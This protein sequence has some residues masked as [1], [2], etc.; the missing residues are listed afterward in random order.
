MLAYNNTAELLFAQASNV[1]SS[2]TGAKSS[3][4]AASDD[5]KSVLN[6]TLSSNSK[7]TL[8]NSSID[9]S[10]NVVQTDDNKVKYNSFKEVQRK[11]AV[12]DSKNTSVKQTSAEKSGDVNTET[13]KLSGSS[14]QYDDSINMLAMMLGLQPDELLKLAQQ[15][16]FSAEDLKD[17]KKL[18]LFLNKLADMMEL[19]DSQK[20]MLNNIAKEVTKQLDTPAET[21]TANTIPAE[22]TAVS[23]EDTDNSG[24]NTGSVDISKLSE[25]IKDKLQQIIQNAEV[26]PEAVKLEVL[27]TIEAMKFQKQGN[28]LSSSQQT[29]ETGISQTTV[30]NTA[31]NTAQET[32]EQLSAEQDNSIKDMKK[33]RDSK[34]EKKAEANDAVETKNGTAVKSAEV[35]AGAGN[36][37]NNQLNE[38]NTQAVAD[39][40]V[41]VANSPAEV[42]KTVFSIP[43]QIKGTEVLKQVV[44][45]A[46]VLLGQDK[47]EMVIQLKPDHLGKLELKVVTEQGIVAAKFI[48]ENQRVKEVIETN[49]QMLKDSLQKQGIA[50][51]SIN[52]Q[53]G[54]DPQSKYTSQ[55]S[56]QGNKNSSGSRVKYGSNEGSSG[57]MAKGFDTLPERFAQYTYEPNSINLTA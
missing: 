26:D 13:E 22:E 8:N 30:G 40:K 9:D 28:S 2:N 21:V 53:V 12:S 43:Q 46:K 41:S 52:V 20:T 44:E 31:L 50:V 37:L 47:S 36:E 32:S 55:N 57:V 6:K 54:Q 49:M 14:D 19:N 11:S 5:F 42:E 27:K 45:Q 3:K 24:K 33:A 25:K 10:K 39:I 18:M 35:Q 23:L 56:F 38:Q 34:D 7:S 1:S 16:G 17:I 48:A 51:D 15:L 4:T 29:A